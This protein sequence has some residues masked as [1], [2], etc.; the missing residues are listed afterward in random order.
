MAKRS[1]ELFDYL[2]RIAENINSSAKDFEQ[3][4]RDLSHPESLASRIKSYEKT[5]DDLVSGLI[6]LVNATYITPIDREDFLDMAI[7]MDDIVDGL[8]A[9]SV[10]FDLYNVSTSNSVMVELAKIIVEQTAEILEATQNLKNRKLTSIREYTSKINQLEKAGD[11]VY[12]KA[13]RDLFSNETADVLEVIK[14]KE[15]YEILE[16][17]TDGCQDVA[18]TLGSIVVKN[19]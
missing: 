5:G 13:L 2:V 9:C 10:R 3:G 1:Q 7:H 8:E 19:A 17:I 12:R 11:A 14:L 6:T 18:D 15:I 16:S 4:L